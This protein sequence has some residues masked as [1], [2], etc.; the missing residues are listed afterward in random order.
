M[1]CFN[2]EMERA[3]KTCLDLISQKKKFSIDITMLR[4]KP[5]NEKHQ[6]LPYYEG[7]YIHRQDNIDFESARE[8]LMEVDKKMVEKRR[9]EMIYNAIET[10]TYTKYEDIT[11]NKEISIYG[12]KHVKTDKIDDYI[13][14][15][16][17]SDEIFEM[18]NYSISGLKNS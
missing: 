17:E 13:L 3:C 15:G 10:L 9:I 4:R 7:K 11:E 8:V 16:C 1:N 12:L 2:C 5:P 14:I 6:M 18:I